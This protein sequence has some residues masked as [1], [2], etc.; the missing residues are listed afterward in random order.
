VLD[1]FE[2]VGVLAFADDLKLYMCV[3]STDDCRLFQQ[4]LD[5]TGLVS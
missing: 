2:N 1:F 5:S 3:G 4:G